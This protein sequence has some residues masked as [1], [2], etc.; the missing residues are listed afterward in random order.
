MPP[1]ATPI[2][3]YVLI[4]HDN[5][6]VDAIYTKQ[7]ENDPNLIIIR[8]KPG[9]TAATIAAQITGPANIILQCHGDKEGRIT[10]SKDSVSLL[11]IG[12]FT[13]NNGDNKSYSDLFGLL[14]R[15]GINSI[16]LGSC[17][18]GSAQYEEALKAA[19]PGCIVQSATGP[20]TIGLSTTIV[21]FASESKGLISPTS[22]F[23]EM[24]DNFNPSTHKNFI[25]Y[26]NK[27]NGE[28]HD[29][30]PELA[31]PHIL[32]LGGNPP[33]KIDLAVEMS[34]LAQHP[35]SEAMAD[36]I[37]R[38]QKHF[39]TDSY[40]TVTT[41]T[42]VKDHS[43][44]TDGSLGPEAENKL[45]QDIADMAVKLQQ[46]YAP[47]NVE[48]KRLA[49]AIT[50]AY[51]DESGA[52]TRMVEAQQ[53]YAEF[54]KQPELITKDEHDYLKALEKNRPIWHDKE[55]DVVIEKLTETFSRTTGNDSVPS[56]DTL[57]TQLTQ[58]G[59]ITPTEF[60][61]GR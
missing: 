58:K 55:L 45:D 24:L 6:N 22:L 25:E 30:D 57:A 27:K 14:P 38:V 10:S 31:M 15:S 47:A 49:Y 23:L 28:Q 40:R 36:A 3:N 32:G 17:Y 9:D 21:K 41:E 35:D 33:K 37:K 26:L 11:F 43:C 44:V 1:T 13:W 42:G 4:G 60:F 29:S 18:G 54:G 12:T 50:A 8:P 51:L 56:N 2:K 52:M 19:P 53:G 59:F 16:S 48:E 46:G 39:D 61:N 34:N 20:M 5:A 7:A